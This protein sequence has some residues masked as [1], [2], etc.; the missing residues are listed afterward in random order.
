MARKRL[1][2][3]IIRVTAVTVTLVALT[4]LEIKMI[5]R[6]QVTVDEEK[7]YTL[8]EKVDLEQ[9]E[10]AD[11][12]SL[13]SATVVFEDEYTDP[14]PLAGVPLGYETQTALIEYCAEYSVPVSI[15]LGLIEHES[16]F[17]EEAVSSTNDY[18]LCQINIINTGWLKEELGVT[19]ILDPEQ[20]IQSGMYILSMY[21]EKYQDWEMALICYN[22]GE[23]GAVR[24]YF[25]NGSY[26]NAY[27][28]S[29]ME[30]SRNWENITEEGF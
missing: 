12:E 25:N 28:S 22:S 26:S 5:V 3:V 6:R 17:D 15:A 20:N 19:D 18:G 1:E 24:N 7:I 16:T 13:T 11:D 30:L 4:L 23:G 27:S 29:V 10:K 9:P 8:S 14:V 21:Y 2:L